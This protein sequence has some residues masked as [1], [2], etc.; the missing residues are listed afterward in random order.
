MIAFSDHVECFEYEAES[1]KFV[2][3]SAA[4]RFRMESILDFDPKM[5]LPRI[6]KLFESC[7]SNEV[8][9][10]YGNLGRHPYLLTYFVD[11]CFDE[12]V[13][14]ECRWD[15]HSPYQDGQ[16]STTVIRL[17]PDFDETV[18]VPSHARR[19]IVF[20]SHAAFRVVGRENYKMMTC[21]F[22]QCKVPRCT[23]G[24]HDVS[25]EPD[26]LHVERKRIPDRSCV[27][28]VDVSNSKT[29]N[30]SYLKLLN[31]FE[32]L[33]NHSVVVRFPENFKYLMPILTASK[34][35]LREFDIENSDLE[36]VYVD[37][38]ADLNEGRRIFCDA[39]FVF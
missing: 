10:V 38:F 31:A 27:V 30:E 20:S 5:F 37:P 34:R 4:D 33:R 1:P 36:R 19:L 12:N 14:F 39:H 2:D 15:T 32:L 8:T 11:L 24:K 17:E 29:L 25:F 23:T 26:A 13:S 18:S 7:A 16:K 3:F 9:V 21:H 35:R 22:G 28:Q 6:Q